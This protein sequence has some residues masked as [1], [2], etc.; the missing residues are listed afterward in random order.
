MQ[1]YTPVGIV[2]CSRFHRNHRCNLGD[3]FVIESRSHQ[4]WLRK[5]C[6][7]AVLRAG[8]FAEVCIWASDT[9]KLLEKH[10]LDFTLLITC[11]AI[12]HST[13]GMEV[14]QVAPRLASQMWWH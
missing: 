6:A 9:W 1:R 14:C 11:H 13:I 5:T 3:E 4:D 7:V 2:E 8:L 12:L 10:Y